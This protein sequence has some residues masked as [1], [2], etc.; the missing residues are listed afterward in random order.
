M[1]NLYVWQV[2]QDEQWGL[3]SVEIPGVG[4]A[5]LIAR[6]RNTADALRDIALLHQKRTGLEVR[7]AQYDFRATISIYTGKEEA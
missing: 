3:I 1:R 5:P 7:L 6:D 4:Q 2:Y